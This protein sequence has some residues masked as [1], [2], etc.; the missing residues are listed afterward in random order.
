VLVEG[1]LR[2]RVSLSKYRGYFCGSEE[3]EGSGI[4]GILLDRECPMVMWLWVGQLEA[5][6]LLLKQTMCGGAQ[7][8]TKTSWLREEGERIGIVVGSM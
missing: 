5:A 2:S 6:D 7:P 1:G 8:S 4:S 3:I